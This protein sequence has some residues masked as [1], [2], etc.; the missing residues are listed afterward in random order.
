MNAIVTVTLRAETMKTTDLIKNPIHWT[1]AR[2]IDGDVDNASNKHYIGQTRVNI[3]VGTQ[4]TTEEYQTPSCR[5][6]RT[7]HRPQG[8]PKNAIKKL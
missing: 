1:D 7:S 5:T 6:V 3:D 4:R 8:K 2:E